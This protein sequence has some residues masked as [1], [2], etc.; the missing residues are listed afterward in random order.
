MPQDL[1]PS[2][3]PAN[4]LGLALLVIAAAQLMLV[5]DD[6]IANI[7]LPTIQNELALSASNLPWVVNGYILTFGALLLFGGRVGDLYGRKRVFQLGLALF[8]L[9]SLFV[10]LAPNGELLIASRVLQGLGASLTAPNALALI[11]TTFPAGEARNKALAIYGAMSGLGIVAGLLLGGVLTG[12]VGWRW[13]FF[14]NIPIGLLVLAGTRTLG[15]AGRHPGRLDL[16]GALT[17]TVGMAALVYAITRGGEHGWTDPLTLAFL[18]TAATLIPLFL[19]IQTRSAQPLLP[20]RVFRDRKPLG[21]LPRHA[22]A[23]CGPHGHLLP[24]DALHAAH[25]GVQPHAHRAGMVTLRRGHRALLGRRDQAGHPHSPRVL[26]PVGMLIAS[27]AVFWLS[28][29][30]RDA[31]YA[32]HLLP[33]I[34]FTAF[35]FGMGFVPLTLTGVHGV[36]SQDSGIASALLNAAQQIGV[37]LG[38]ALLATVAVTTTAHQLPDAL[39]ALYQGRTSGNEELVTRASDALVQGYSSGLAVGALILVVAA[40]ITALVINARPQPSAEEPTQT[41]TH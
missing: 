27:A 1:K 26:A 23:R 32:L 20:L 17:S 19:W 33:G 22:A 9:A 37:A 2:P 10:G 13:V 3:D 5:L 39:A 15:D 36:A 16:P 28:T 40:V 8:T 31:S 4:R 35:G 6:S 29:M 38:L 18:A 34:F 14:I 7:A 21:V 12:T 30:D 11:A 41:P 25:P 24:G